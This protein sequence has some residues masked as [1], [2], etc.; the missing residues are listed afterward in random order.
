MSHEVRELTGEDIAK[1]IP[2]RRR[3]NLALTA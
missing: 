1:A 2:R 3:E